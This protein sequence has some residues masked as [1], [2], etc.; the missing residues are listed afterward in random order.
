MNI[1]HAI[2]VR[3][4]TKK[5]KIFFDKGHTL[6]EKTMFRSRRAYQTRDVLRGISFEVKKG[7][8]IGLIG[9]NGCGKSTTL[10]LL[11]KIM[12]PDSGTIEM[13][14]RVSSLIELG[15]GFHPDM[16]GRE[17][18]YINAS[19]FGLTK[20][21]I[22]ERVE[23]IINFSELEEFIDL[24]VRTYSSGMYM[25]LAFSVAIN[26]DAEILLIDE[27]LAVGDAGFQMKC[28]NRLKEIKASGTTIV[29]VSHSMGQIEQIC[30]RS[31]WIHEG[32]IKAEGKPK[33]VHPQ[34]LEYI[35]DHRLAVAEK[36]EEREKEKQKEESQK[37][38]QIQDKK[39]TPTEK[40]KKRWGNENVTIKN[41]QLTDSFG[42]ERVCF[43]TGDFVGIKID[44]EMNTIVRDAVVG[45]GISRIDGVHCYGTNT[46]IDKVDYFDIVKSGTISFEI[47][48]LLLLQGNYVLDVAIECDMGIPVD[49]YREA[50]K[51]EVI[52]TLDDVGVSRLQHRWNMEL[53]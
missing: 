34:Y 36:A 39:T 50:C 43:K 53:V 15:A 2:E 40:K 19:I 10:K 8:A 52:S 5:F 23:D 47:E 11:T 24:P 14:G 38:Q 28:F 37:E 25:R 45:I 46:R 7:E 16:S 1:E 4:I 29:I 17:N 35:G 41:V 30:D 27:I 12:Y 20:K 6:K 18:I 49:F 44:Y 9:H 42:Q 31:I 3:D 21:E 48:S 22:D 32:K 26:V 33:E 51:F 13:C